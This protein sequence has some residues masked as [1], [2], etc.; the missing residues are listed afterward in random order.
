MPCASALSLIVRLAIDV[1]LFV[2]AGHHEQGGAD[3]SRRRDGSVS[4]PIKSCRG[5][6]CKR[7]PFCTHHVPVTSIM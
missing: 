6:G 1:G 4:C 3:G 7:H 2:I 5:A